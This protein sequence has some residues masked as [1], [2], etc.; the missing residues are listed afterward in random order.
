MKSANS[1]KKTIKTIYLGA[2]HAGFELKEKVKKWLEKEGISYGDLGNQVLNPNDD[3]PDYAIKVAKRVAKEKTLGVLFC[4]SAE[5]MCIAANK[6]KRIRAVNPQDVIKTEFA[7]NHE[8]ANVLCL[9]GGAS[10]NPQPGLSLKDAKNMI[11]AFLNSSFSG[12]ERH[13]RRLKKIERLMK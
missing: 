5:G 7:R 6:I 12:E 2:D 11:R 13:I 9:A 3:Y 4:G 1:T 10:K 8:D